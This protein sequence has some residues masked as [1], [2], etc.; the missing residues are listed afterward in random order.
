MLAYVNDDRSATRVLTQSSHSGDEGIVRRHDRIRRVVNPGA[1][2]LAAEGGRATGLVFEL[3]YAQAGASEI[4]CWKHHRLAMGSTNKRH[5]LTKQLTKVSHRTRHNPPRN[6]PSDNRLANEID[7]LLNAHQTHD[8]PLQVIVIDIR[9][10]LRNFHPL[11]PSPL[12]RITI[13]VPIHKRSELTPPKVARRF[14]K[15]M[16]DMEAGND[17][18]QIVGAGFVNTIRLDGEV[19]R[20]MVSLET[21]E[22]TVELDAE[23]GQGDRGVGW[24][25]GT[26]DGVE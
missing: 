15:R 3:E 23:G 4:G 16:L 22:Y 6:T 12:R 8:Q 14:E 24:K 7:I 26:G 18:L 5:Q 20:P 19:R 2:G 1:L 21:G 9:I 17:I 25:D 11:H 13:K 10:I